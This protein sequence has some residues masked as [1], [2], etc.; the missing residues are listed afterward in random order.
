MAFMCPLCSRICGL[1]AC[2]MNRSGC[3]QCQLASDLAV[4]RC[5]AGCLAPSRLPWQLRDT[6]VLEFTAE[7]PD[8][9]HV[10]AAQDGNFPVAVVAAARPADA[11]RGA[12]LG[13]GGGIGW[14]GDGGGAGGRGL[15][16]IVG[17]RPAAAAKEA[18]RRAW[19][20]GSGRC[21]GTLRSR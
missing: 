1:R 16:V 3:C 18:A 7:R 4:M 19:R 6:A 12:G 5:H 13:A 11:R 9:V 17:S 21:P 2:G 10:L 15:D 14:G 8:A 20:A